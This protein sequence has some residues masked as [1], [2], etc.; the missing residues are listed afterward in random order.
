[1][2]GDRRAFVV[3]G[4]TG[5]LGEPIARRLVD[6]GD[7]VLLVG[8][9]ESKLRSL[10]QRLGLGDS[11][12]WAGDMLLPE[13]ADAAAAYACAQ[14]GRLDGLIHLVGSFHMGTPATVAASDLYGELFRSNVLSAV[15]A[16]ASVL[17]RLDGGGYLVYLSS[18][19][20]EEPMAGSAPYAAAKAALH[21]WVR[22]LSRE[23]KDGNVHANVVVTSRIDTPA[24]R[25]LFPGADFS[26][27]VP[28]DDLAALVAMLT[29][30]A[31]A[32]VHGAVIRACGTFALEMPGAGAGRGP[33]TTTGGRP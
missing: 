25:A 12:Y 3:T 15:T 1:M 24:R 13:E 10:C 20:A 29:S 30:P 21:A 18:L 27:W 23:V 19:L 16:T 14:H 6:R 32:G 5:N 2:G 17:P 7:G 9:D 4:A 11:A 22:A 8:R 31:A 26:T 28:A 33:A